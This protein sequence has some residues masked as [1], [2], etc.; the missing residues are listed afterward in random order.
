MEFRNVALLI[1]QVSFYTHMKVVVEA[2]TLRLPHA[3]IMMIGESNA[4]LLETMGLQHAFIMI[5][6]SNA[7]LLETLGP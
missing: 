1:P 4:M 2:R 5:G 7:M 6:E 3:F